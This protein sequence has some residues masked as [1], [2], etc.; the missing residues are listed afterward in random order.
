MNHKRNTRCRAHARGVAHP[1][2]P[3]PI[4]LVAALVLVLATPTFAQ[5]TTGTLRGQVLDP[6]GAT[7]AGAKVL[8]TNQETGVS[9]E[10]TTSSAGTYNFPSVLP[11]TYTVA[12]EVAGFKK[13]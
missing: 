10:A 7:V 4:A 3:L 8:A 13:F 9:L 2:Q 5:R 12:V 11:G 1:W 6:V